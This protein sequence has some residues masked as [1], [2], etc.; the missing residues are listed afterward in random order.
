M[1]KIGIFYGPQLGSVEKVAHVIE[2]KFGADKVELIAVKNIS[3]TELNRFDKVIFGMSTIGKTNWDSD[4]KDTDWDVFATLIEKANWDDKKV[5]MYCLGDHVQYPQHFVDA[6]GWVYE[7][8]KNT[9]A[10]VVG[11]CSTEG[12]VYE[13]SEGLK[14]GH[15]LGLPVDEDNEADKT[16]VRVENWINRLVNEFGY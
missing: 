1:S 15:F 3:E 5:A 8:L 9:S 7:R 11:F 16:A 13:E 12:Y 6:L 10:E 2:S 4:Y 14:D